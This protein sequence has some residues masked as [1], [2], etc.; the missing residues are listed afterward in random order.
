M[1]IQPSLLLLVASTLASQSE[2]LGNFVRRGGEVGGEGQV[3]RQAESEPLDN[4][5]YASEVVLCRITVVDTLMGGMVEQYSEMKHGWE[6]SLHHLGEELGCVLIRDNEETDELYSITIPE[7]IDYAHKSSIMKG[8][9]LLS[10]KGAYVMH[11]NQ[12][13]VRDDA[14]F[15]VLDPVPIHMRRLSLSPPSTIG[16]RSIFIVR[17]STS[18]ST[19]S[20]SL[21][22]IQQGIATMNAVSFQSQ[23]H[24]C[25]FGQLQWKLAGGVDVF[26]PQSISSFKK[27]FDLL[28]AAITVAK[29]LLDVND[30]RELGDHIMFC[31]PGGMEGWVA[32]AAINHWSSNFNEGFHLSLSVLMHEISHNLGLLHSGI[33]SDAYADLTGY[34][35]GG[36]A[37]ET[38]PRKCFNG[39]KSWQLGWYQTRHLTVDPEKSFGAIKV[40]SFVDFPKAREDEP[41]LVNIADQFFLMFNRAKD[42]NEDTQALQDLLT[43]T[44]DTPSWSSSRAGLATGD[45]FTLSNFRPGRSLVVEVCSTQDGGSSRADFM[46]VSIALDRSF[47]GD[48]ATHRPTIPPVKA[49]VDAPGAECKHLNTPCSQH[50]ECCAPD[51]RCL[52]RHGAIKCRYCRL[53]GQRCF[54]DSECCSGRNSCDLNSGVCIA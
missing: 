49:E 5:T 53:T 9:L 10:I 41:V 19:P 42:F 43:V 12:L 51:L 36:A 24:A 21:S 31:Q 45:R 38:F 15:E 29:T 44:E 47:C 22:E 2:S 46:I 20:K 32:V 18:D 14:V 37:S 40:G 34:M 30:M 33:G 26:L 13:F 48:E 17:V 28:Q 39:H 35:G 1:M 7:S 8:T 6:T 52:D 23:F 3:E 4:G 16:T 25:S 50:S 54:D 27:P 11:D